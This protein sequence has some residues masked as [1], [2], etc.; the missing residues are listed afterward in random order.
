MRQGRFRR[1]GTGSEKPGGGGGSGRRSAG[2]NLAAKPVEIGIGEPTVGAEIVQSRSSG[3]NG[4]EKGGEGGRSEA[5]VE[6]ADK[7]R[8]L[9]IE[10]RDVSRCGRIVGKGEKRVERKPRF[11]GWNANGLHAVDPCDGFGGAV[12]GKL[13]EAFFKPQGKGPRTMAASQKRMGAFMTGA[14]GRFQG[15]GRGNND[16]GAFMRLAKNAV[17][18]TGGRRLEADA[19]GRT[20]G[21][22]ANNLCGRARGGSPKALFGIIKGVGTD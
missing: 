15:V 13:G 2:D 19:D 4:G 11:G 17:T 5:R 3:G 16:N 7:Q 8:G 22:D 6:G 10:G 21:D 1:S 9:P 12:P 18:A 20:I 14:K